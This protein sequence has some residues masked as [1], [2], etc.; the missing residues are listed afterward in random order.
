MSAILDSKGRHVAD[1]QPVIAPRPAGPW[2]GNHDA[3]ADGSWAGPVV[4]SWCSGLMREGDPALPTSHSICEM[5]AVR[6]GQE[7]V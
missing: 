1:D 6:F 4:C 2:Q 3:R 5:C 7:V